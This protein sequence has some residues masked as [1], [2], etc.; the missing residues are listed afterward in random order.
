MLGGLLESWGRNIGTYVFR[1]WQF[2]NV[3]MVC[4]D[5]LPT[6]CRCEIRRR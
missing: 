3:R 1:F 6:I 5:V 4:K 2:L